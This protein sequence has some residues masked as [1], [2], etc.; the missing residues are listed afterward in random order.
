MSDQMSID[1]VTLERLRNARKRRGLTQADVSERLDMSRTT[2][3]AIEKGERPLRSDELIRFAELYG[4]PINE[5]LRTVAPPTD[6][7]IEFRVP[8]ERE[9]LAS[10]LE[11]AANL[12]QSLADDYIELEKITGNQIDP[13]HYPPAN[14]P[15]G[16][17]E[18]FGQALAASERNR[19]GIGDAPALRLRELLDSDAG[20]RTFSISLP[21]P[22]A[23]LYIHSE[24]YGPCIAINADHPY[25]RQR[26]SLAHEYAHFLTSR[27]RPE[28]T[29]LHQ[30][31][32]VPA[33]ERM[34]DSFAQA[35]LIPRSR[36]TRRFHDLQRPRGRIAPADLLTLAAYFE[37]SFQ[38]IALALEDA[39]LLPSGTW[40]RLSAQGFKPEEGRQILDLA[41]FEPDRR[42]LPPRY[43]R[44]AAHAYW[45][46]EISEG[47]LAQFL[48]VDRVAARRRV[49]ELGR[50]DGLDEDG[51]RTTVDL[52]SLSE[53]DLPLS[54]AR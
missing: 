13:M 7:A 44:L 50:G 54:R 53:I 43:E 34:A 38:A 21:S 48:H 2:I 42:L 8:A 22:V 49:G 25:E 39:R 4:I 19:L 15:T 18:S 17:P 12:L 10:Q 37:V 46:G 30:Y 40:D 28:V 24:L 27:S 33:N 35:F 23:G 6:F 29:V 51:E 20:I 14:Q 16:G 47:E 9:A 36:L 1:K 5:L 26:W 52:G 32:R 41:S 45:S 31:S 11:D 3:V